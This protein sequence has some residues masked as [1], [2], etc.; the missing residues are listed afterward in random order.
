MARIAGVDIPD[1]KRVEVA[2]TYIRGIGSTLA[3]EILA[4]TGIDPAT[5]AK[6]LSAAQIKALHLAV[7]PYPTEG[8]LARQVEEDIKRLKQIGSYRGL[9]HSAGLPV[10]GQRTRSNARTRRGKRRT[11]GAMR[12]EVLTRT[13]QF[14]KE[15]VE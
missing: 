12:K 7:D 15:K 3:Q 5:R 2:L 14:E 13:G 8:E 11:V 6:D 10:R 9:R 1:E 4:Q